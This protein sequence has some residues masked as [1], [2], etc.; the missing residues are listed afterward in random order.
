MLV[1]FCSYGDKN[2]KHHPKNRRDF[3]GIKT[4]QPVHV[5]AKQ[6]AQRSATYHQLCN[7]SAAHHCQTPPK[8]Y[9]T[10]K[11][12]L[13]KGKTMPK[14]FLIAGAVAL[15]LAAAVCAETTKDTKLDWKFSKENIQIFAPP[16]DA[17]IEQM[18]NWAYSL[19]RPFPKDTEK[20]GGN[21]KYQERVALLKIDVA[22]QI[23][24]S[25]PDDI[26]LAGAWTMQVSPR[27][28]LAEQDKKNFPQLENLYAE[29]KQ[30][31]DEHGRKLDLF[32]Y[33][34]MRVRWV[35][36]LDCL[37]FGSHEKYIAWGNELLAEYNALLE[38][39][40]LG[41]FAE[42]FYGD[43]YLFLDCLSQYDKK[44]E[45][46]AARE[47]MCA[48]VNTRESELKTAA[49]YRYCGPSEPFTTPEGQAV[50]RAWMERV[51]RHIAVTEGAFDRCDLYSI[52][53]YVLDELYGNNA[54]T[55]EECLAF[56]KELENQLGKD[57]AHDAYRD[58]IYNAYFSVLDRDMQ[59]LLKEETITDEALEHCFASAKCLFYVGESAY[60]LDGSRAL[61]RL[62]YNHGYEL[63]AR[64]AP[65]QQ[66]FFIK[67]FK[68][69]LTETEQFEKDWM[70]AGKYLWHESELP[71]LRGFLSRL[72][73][74]DQEMALTG[75]ALD[76]T[77][78]DLKSLRGKVVLLEFWATWCG[79]CI[80]EIPALKERYA[81]FHSRGF[82]I[83]GI[84]IDAAEDKAK[85]VEFVQERQLPWIQLHDSKSEL[86]NRLHGVSVPYCLL[87]DRE[88]R[89]ILQEARGELLKRKLEEMF[90]EE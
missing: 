76:G 82:E 60:G 59:H 38:G 34:I 55:Y 11:C 8:P 84:S 37:K 14:T 62:F 23:I 88:G 31:N 86:F 89:V 85:L 70:A 16:M 69:L 6:E 46:A 65:A 78:F 50:Q 17:S 80:K 73:L 44:F 32:T 83:V 21:E 51:F 27:F 25:K 49:F 87:L 1:A 20:W 54:A 63:F 90:T 48:L 29:L 13:T 52:T 72:Q 18:M 53:W 42:E 35:V 4:E 26:S 56:I 81:A 40:P 22:Q 15:L 71:S 74:V 57:E 24:A 19:E 77:A 9:N 68:E 47:E 2:N 66:E 58:I 7:P 36:V 12:P 43:K 64:C 28:I 3:D 45:S 75:T 67:A 5:A 41:K 39:K 10:T 33:D 79:P 61:T 30:Q